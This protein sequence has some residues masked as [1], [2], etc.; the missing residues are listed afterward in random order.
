MLRSSSGDYSNAN[1][2]L[3]AIITVPKTV[4]A[5]NNRKNRIIEN[6]NLFTDYMW[7]INNT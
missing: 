4:V 6:C 2:L 7:K 3:S 1:I 5:A